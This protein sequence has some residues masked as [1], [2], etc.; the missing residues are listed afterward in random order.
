VGNPPIFNEAHSLH[1]LILIDR[2]PKQTHA[3]D[4]TKSGRN[5]HKGREAG[6]S[7]LRNSVFKVDEIWF[8][9]RAIRVFWIARNIRKSEFFIH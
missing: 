2:A 1:V 7:C 5:R 6:L 3:S 8:Q 4:L 9:F